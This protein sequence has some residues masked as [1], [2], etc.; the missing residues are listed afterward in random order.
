[1]T[2]ALANRAG[3][4]SA[5]AYLNLEN[6]ISGGAGDDGLRD[7]VSGGA[8]TDLARLDRADVPRLLERCL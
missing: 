8:G 6:R 1:M 4:T 2:I 7:R 5:D 3:L